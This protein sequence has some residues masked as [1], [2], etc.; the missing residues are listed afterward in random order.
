M[1]ADRAEAAF[2]AAFLRNRNVD[3]VTAGDG[4]VALAGGYALCAA[5][6]H[7]QVA[8]AAGST[9][10]LSAD[11]LAVLEAFY[12]ARGLP[13]RL[14]LRED[15]LERDRS[16]LEHAGFTI[17]PEAYVFYES[18]GTPEPRGDGIAVR[19]AGDR[20]AWARLV[21]SAFAGSHDDDADTPRSI[22]LAAAAAAAVFIAD[23]DGVPA[24]GAALGLAGEFAYLYAGAVL[25]AF[26]RRGVHRA[27]VRARIADA[28]A[29]GMG[30][31]MTKVLR[32][33]AA[34]EAFRTA[35]FTPAIVTRRARRA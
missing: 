5:R 10:A 4:A 6:S 13:A 29:R 2:W 24:G 33:S 3:D 25:P 31:A 34:D 14:E 8:L 26:R 27:L 18:D 28:R 30:R 1:S 21:T 23:V 32:G 20:T 17:A 22:E 16:V 35:G 9:R 7:H 15:A 11:D 19:A 12:R